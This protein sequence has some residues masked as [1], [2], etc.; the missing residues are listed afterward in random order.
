MTGVAQVLLI[1]G[2]TA[3]RCPNISQ[4]TKPVAD[5]VC[6]RVTKGYVLPR[7][8]L[9]LLLPPCYRNTPYQE[10]LVTPSVNPNSRFF[11]GI[12]PL[13]SAQVGHVDNS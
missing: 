12:G 9:Q 10:H 6:L 3:G 11:V 8:A 7:P 2:K 4:R 5:W 1:L 13:G